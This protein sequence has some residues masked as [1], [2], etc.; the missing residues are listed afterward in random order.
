MLQKNKWHYARIGVKLTLTIC[1][2]KAFIL[3]SHTVW[4]ISDYIIYPYV[5]IRYSSNRKSIAIE[6]SQKN[7]KNLI[8]DRWPVAY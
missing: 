8:S 4:T 7:K 6:D 3:Y 2:H 5:Y 1:T